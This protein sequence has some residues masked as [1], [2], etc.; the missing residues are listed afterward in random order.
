[1]AGE[2]P[3][4]AWY[5]SETLAGGPPTYN[6]SW[7]DGSGFKDHYSSQV[8]AR[9][10][11]QSGKTNITSYITF[12][13][14]LTKP[15]STVTSPANG[16]Y[17]GTLADI[18]G[19][20]L[21]SPPNASGVSGVQIAMRRGTDNKWWNGAD[22][23]ALH[24]G[25]PAEDDWLATNC[26]SGSCTLPWTKTTGLPWSPTSSSMTA[27]AYS[28]YSRA[29]DVAK[30][31]QTALADELVFNWD[32]TGAVAFTTPTTSGNGVYSVS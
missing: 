28:L 3:A 22:W 16:S 2:C 30:N 29:Y 10:A 19:T 5:T 26:V 11:D 7:I 20:A 17:I 31:T 32:I 14:D 23:T 24:A 15:T 27:G 1:M 6:W 21:D 12:Y 8:K 13:Y 9:T 4:N 18:T 25:T